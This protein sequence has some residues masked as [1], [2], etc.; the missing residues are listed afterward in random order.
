MEGCCGD[1]ASWLLADASIYTSTGRGLSTQNPW[2]S[3]AG[4]EVVSLRLGFRDYSEGWKDLEKTGV[5]HPE[6]LEYPA[7]HQFFCL[8]KTTSYGESKPT[9]H[10]VPTMRESPWHAL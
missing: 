1:P 5:Y 3:G 7:L 2:P 9:P 4:V 6:G 10:V 8:L